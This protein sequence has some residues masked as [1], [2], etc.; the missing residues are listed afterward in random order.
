MSN[1]QRVRLTQNFC[2]TWNHAILIPYQKRVSTALAS[3][4]NITKVD[5]SSQNASMLCA[6]HILYGKEDLI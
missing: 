4:H 3:I 5:R 6:R 2:Q 1:L